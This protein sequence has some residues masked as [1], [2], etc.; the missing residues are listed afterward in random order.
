M[1]CSE[2]NCKQIAEYSC[3]CFSGVT[4]TDHLSSHWGMGEHRLESLFLYL[5]D[6]SY[7]KIEKFLSPL[8]KQLSS[9]LNS[10]LKH[11]NHLISQ[12]KS[13]TKQAIQ[14]LQSQLGFVKSLLLKIKTKKVM[15]KEIDSVWNALNNCGT[16]ELLD[17][18][19]F[20]DEIKVNP[21]H[22]YMKK[23]I[24]EM[25]IG[26]VNQTMISKYYDDSNFRE[27]IFFLSEVNQHTLKLAC[28]NSHKLIEKIRL[29]NLNNSLNVSDRSE[30]RLEYQ[31]T[32]DSFS[33]T[34]ESSSSYSQ[35]INFEDLS[36]FF[37]KEILVNILKTDLA[38]RI[39]KSLNDVKADKSIFEK[40]EKIQ[41]QSMSELVNR[42]EVVGC[43]TNQEI[44][45]IFI[46]RLNLIEK[47]KVVKQFFFL[48][49]GDV[50]HSFFE[51][52]KNN[53]KEKDYQLMFKE[54]L[55]GQIG[56]KKSVINDLS[57]T[58]DEEIQ[59][60]K[61]H[62]RFVYPLNVF[63]TENL[64]NDLQSIF[65]G[66]Y[67]L[68]MA[69]YSIKISFK[70]VTQPLEQYENKVFNKFFTLRFSCI[71]LINDLIYFI[72]EE[73]I[74]K[75][76][77]NLWQKINSSLNFEESVILFRES[78]NSIKIISAD[79]SK[80]GK[81]L[82]ALIKVFSEFSDLS[83]KFIEQVNLGNDF[84]EFSSEIKSIT[85]KL[86]MSLISFIDSLHSLPYENTSYFTKRLK[87]FS[88]LILS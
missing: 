86:K 28:D 62:Y 75:V 84:E 2:K 79:T 23:L 74:E 24:T 19:Q 14:S 20:G 36:S 5:D 44:L 73:I 4:C 25:G 46:H 11:S 59:D 48:G 35:D 47:C 80:S 57:F 29:N 65:L 40:A 8:S 71:V 67:S 41:I 58:Y 55:E 50:F 60:I 39:R 66:L 61:I 9:A 6:S 64:V 76:W 33:N 38:L 10:C 21:V 87:E 72:L 56:I 81:S 27:T 54:S 16:K 77:K 78:I 18:F 43:L 88:F 13:N 7:D 83:E 63:F 30:V 37:T 32:V 45:N 26:E 85:T 51:K 1:L 34:F 49:Q 82:K 15:K 31:S 17:L 68:R 12:I 52:I 3:C 69:E 42:V 53:P 70:K 22:T